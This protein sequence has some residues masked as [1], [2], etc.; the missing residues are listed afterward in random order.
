MSYLPLTTIHIITS[1][2]ACIL[3]GRNCQLRQF[4][5]ADLEN[6]NDNFGEELQIFVAQ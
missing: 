6:N 3:K 1:F 4:I 5:S 2:F